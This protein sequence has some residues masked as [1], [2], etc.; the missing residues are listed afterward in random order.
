MPKRRHIL[1]LLVMLTVSVSAQ[2]FICATN[3]GAITITKY[4]G[5]GG[6]VS[7]PSEITGLRVTGIGAEA[8][9]G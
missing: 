1:L 6:S 2:D 3:N 5:S 4:T 9:L 8:F 7:I